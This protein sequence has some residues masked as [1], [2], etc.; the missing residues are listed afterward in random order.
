MTKLVKIAVRNL[1]RYRRRTLLTASLI[2]IGVIAVIVFGATAGAFK[3]LIISCI[4]SSTTPT[5]M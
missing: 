4:C 1:A 2:A 5:R 3:G